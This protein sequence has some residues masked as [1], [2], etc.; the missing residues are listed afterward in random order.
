MHRYQG[1]N[2]NRFE[3][4]PKRSDRKGH[5][6]PWGTAASS[7]SGVR[8][9]QAGF[10]DTSDSRSAFSTISCED[11]ICESLEQFRDH[12]TLLRIRMEYAF[13][14]ADAMARQPLASED[15]VRTLLAA[16]QSMDAEF[17]NARRSRYG[18]QDIHTDD[19]RISDRSKTCCARLSAHIQDR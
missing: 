8:L 13:S 17:K 1:P 15:G 6:G 9:L 10:C 19:L 5:S 14:L 7:P 18:W 11:S 12:L 16:I 4:H 3:G 2:S